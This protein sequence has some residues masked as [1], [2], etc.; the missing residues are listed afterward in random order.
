[1]LRRCLITRPSTPLTRPS[2][3]SPHSAAS[4]MLATAAVAV[5]CFS[6]KSR[7]EPRPPRIAGPPA[8]VPPETAVRSRHALSRQPYARRSRNRPH[9]S[10]QRETATVIY[11]GQHRGV[12]GEPAVVRID[13][14]AVPLVGKAGDRNAGGKMRVHEHDE[15]DTRCA[16]D[17]QPDAG[18]T[19]GSEQARQQ[20]EDRRGDADHRE[21]DGERSVRSQSAPERLAIAK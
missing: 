14:A 3:L 18:R 11:E 1:M 5:S 7:N 4:S 10:T 15:K 20:E 16:G 2:A 9:Q 12:A 21:G 13:E 17:P 19:G 8:A 6:T